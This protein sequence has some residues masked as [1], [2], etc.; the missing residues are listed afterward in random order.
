MKR[1]NPQTGKPF[2]LGDA[3]EDGRL[4]YGYTTR[5]KRNGYFIE[6]W[7]N[8]TSRETI[9]IK[10]LARKKMKYDNPV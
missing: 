9:R 8:A 1:I 2:R 3:R 7:L 6:I 4:F 5:V 10:D